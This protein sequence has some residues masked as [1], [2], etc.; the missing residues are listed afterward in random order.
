MLLKPR[1]LEVFDALMEQGSVS[2]AAVRLGLS[3]PAVSIALSNL[4]KDLGFR[5][6]Y[7]TKGYFAPTPEAQRLH[8]EAELSLLAFSRFLARAREIAGGDAGSIT[9]AANGASAINFLPRVIALYRSEAPGVTVDLKVRSSRQVAA[10]VAGG[11]IDIGMIDAPMPVVG[12]R[13]ESV[14]LP[15]GAIL[16][17]AHPLGAR[18]RLG[19]ADLAGETMIGITG[20]H[21]IDRAVARAFTAAGIELNRPVTASF[22]AIARNMVR[23]GVGV[24]M[25]DA[26]NGAV[27]ADDGVVWRPFDPPVTYELAILYHPER[28]DSPP[29]AR[30]LDLIRARLEEARAMTGAGEALGALPQL[31]HRSPGLRRTLPA[32]D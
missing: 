6:F 18:R 3:Q 13:G 16:P 4:E 1:H 22:F 11:Q 17:A 12:L 28:A 5:L 9:L 20:D 25:V 32:P 24:A 14:F 15:C 7:R 23:E 30:M 27:A 2:R 8:G 10:W 19:P 31:G 29:V 26:M 21:P